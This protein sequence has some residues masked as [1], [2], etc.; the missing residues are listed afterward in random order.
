[1]AG[2]TLARSAAGVGDKTIRQDVGNLEQIRSWF[3]RPLWEMEPPDADA[4]FGR[5]LRTA[6]TSTKAHKAKALTVYFAY[7]DL[8]SSPT[9]DRYSWLA[10]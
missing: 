6:A 8:A 10:Q 7:I 3:G 4:Y 1:M 9:P 2:L 5:V